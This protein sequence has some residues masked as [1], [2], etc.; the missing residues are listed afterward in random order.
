ME[1]SDRL[2]HLVLLAAGAAIVAI[3]IS[4]LRTKHQTVV[5]TAKSIHDQLDALDP[6]AR[7]AVIARLTSGAAKDVQARL[8]RT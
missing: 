7:G 1:K 8:G 6:V 3:A 5:A 2:T 4:Q